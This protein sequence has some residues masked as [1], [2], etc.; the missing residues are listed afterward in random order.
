MLPH[1]AAAPMPADPP[2]L[3]MTLRDGRPVALRPVVPE[4]RARLAEGFAELSRESRRLRFLGSVSTLNDAQLRYLTDVDGR[5]HVAWGALDL[6]NPDAPG[7]GVGRM[8]RLG[9]GGVRRRVL[10]DRLGHGP[11]AGRGPAA[12]GGARRRGA[13]CRRGHAA[14]RD[15]ARERADVGVD[16]PPGRPEGGRRRRAGAGPG[17]PRR[18]RRQRDGGPTLPRPSPPSAGPGR[19]GRSNARAAKA[20]SHAG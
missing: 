15:R 17:P 4:D 7:F 16:V 9:P 19:T 3:R 13:R 12:A 20:R 18:S 11:G 10:V 5:D 6:T 8:I 2:V 1:A 14:R